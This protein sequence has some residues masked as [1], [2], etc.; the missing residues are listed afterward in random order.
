M[1]KRINE[2]KL[3]PSEKERKQ[4][5]YRNEN[6]KTLK[7]VENEKKGEREE[8]RKIKYWNEK[9][10]GKNTQWPNSINREEEEGGRRGKGRKREKKLRNGKKSR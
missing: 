4:W 6:K 10:E 9:K 7:K 3:E 1:G 2:R 8:G 5:T